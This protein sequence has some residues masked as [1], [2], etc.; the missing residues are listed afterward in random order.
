ML[1][2]QMFKDVLNL[3]YQIPN[4]IWYS[5]FQMK[6]WTPYFLKKSQLESIHNILWILMYAYIKIYCKYINSACIS[7]YT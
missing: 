3:E 7:I 4:E 6:L 1:G 5:K 2:S